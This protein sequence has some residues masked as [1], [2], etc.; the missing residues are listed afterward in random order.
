MLSGPKQELLDKLLR[1][2]LADNTRH[3]FAKVPDDAIPLSFAQET[4]WRVSQAAGSLAYNETITVKKEGL[5]DPD[6]LDRSLTEIISR[7]EIWRTTYENDSGTLRQ[8]IHSP[9]STC[10]LQLTDLRS[11][12]EVDRSFTLHSLAS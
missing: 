10:S 1:G 2:E 3:A 9:P 11:F 4:M 7:H 12:P 6:V 5:L 8:R